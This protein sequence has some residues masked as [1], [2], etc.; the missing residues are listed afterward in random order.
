MTERISP[1]NINRLFEKYGVP[2]E[3]D[4]LSIDLDGQD[5]W[6]WALLDYFPRVVIIEY[7]PAL[8]IDQS[9]SIPFDVS[10]QWDGT[11]YY[12]ASL[13][14]LN[15][16]GISKGY[17]LLYANAVN[18]FFV[19]NDQIANPEDFKYEDIYNFRGT[20]NYL[21]AD[22]LNRAFKHI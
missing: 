10:H 8:V 1:L 6:V 13:L 2:L 3:F 12:G 18:A 19:R 11:Q 20:L 9:V 7:N 22:P 14:A 4:L 16:L 17:T 21:R 5:F 15:K